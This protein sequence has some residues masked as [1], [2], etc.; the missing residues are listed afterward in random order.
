MEGVS[1]L[2]LCIPV[3]KVHDGFPGYQLPRQE[4]LDLVRQCEQE[5]HSAGYENFALRAEDDIRFY[6]SS[7]EKLQRLQH[8]HNEDKLWL[9]P[10]G[11][12]VR[13]APWAVRPGE[14]TTAVPKVNLNDQQTSQK[15]AIDSAGESDP[16]PPPW[17]VGTDV[18]SQAECFFVDQQHLHGSDSW[19]LRLA[20]NIKREAAWARLRATH[21]WTQKQGK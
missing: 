2:H 15:A 6:A 11:R 12:P 7:D 5:V 17:Q 14:T 10:K 4:F 3:F 16:L 13:Q 21:A 1:A 9:I 18:L 20:N 19:T 8:L